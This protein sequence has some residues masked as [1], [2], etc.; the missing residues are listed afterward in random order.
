MSLSSRPLVQLLAGDRVVIA[1]WPSLGP[2][3]VIETGTRFP[4]M[5]PNRPTVLLCI[6]ALL[7][8]PHWFFA[9]ECLHVEDAE[10]VQPLI[11]PTGTTGREEVW[12]LRPRSDA[13]AS[14]ETP[15]S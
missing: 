14:Q 8:R 4:E 10:S 1:S 6:D 5:Y 12:Y 9:D 2:C 3:T 13:R 11:I 7:D 15:Q